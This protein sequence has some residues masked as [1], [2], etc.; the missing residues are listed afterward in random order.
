MR[1]ALAPQDNLYSLV[2]GE[3]VWVIG[4]VREVLLDTPALVERIA[5]PETRLVTLTVTEKGYLPGSRAAAILAEA[6]ARRETGLTIISCDNLPHNGALL[7]EAV[8]AASGARA[9]W[10]AAPL[11]LPADDG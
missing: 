11:R 3:E 4:A 8:L 7:E 2:V 5:S 1:D 6:L 10:I 9:E